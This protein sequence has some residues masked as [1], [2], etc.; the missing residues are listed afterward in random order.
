MEPGHIDREDHCEARSRRRC[1]AGRNGARSYR[2]GGLVARHQTSVGPHAAMEPGH[3]DREDPPPPYPPSPSPPQPQWSPVIS[4][5]RT[6]E[7]PRAAALATTP[8][9]SPVISTGRTAARTAG[10]E[11]AAVAAMEP[12]HID[13]EDR[14]PNLPHLTCTSDG[15]LRT[16]VADG[17]DRDGDAGIGHT[18]L[19]PDQGAS[20]ARERSADRSARHTMVALPPGMCGRTPRNSKVTLAASPRS[21]IATRST[22]WL[23]TRPRSQRSLVNSTASRSHTN[24]EY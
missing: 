1:P 12:G 5:G 3:I 7:A 9:W 4:T 6:E 15:C 8:Q 2:P 22:G 14:S 19:A 21:M 13:R 20:A 23:I 10:E 18:D 17:P 11:G 24:S 16:V